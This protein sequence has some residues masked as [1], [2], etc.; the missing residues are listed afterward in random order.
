MFFFKLFK[1]QLTIFDDNLIVESIVDCY[2][3]AELDR[4]SVELLVRVDVVGQGETIATDEVLIRVIICLNKSYFS[5]WLVEEFFLFQ[6]Q[7]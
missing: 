4:I 2:L 6:F 3:D 5:C 7:L 1:S